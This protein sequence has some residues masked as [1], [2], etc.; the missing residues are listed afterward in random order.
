MALRLVRELTSLQLRDN[1]GDESTSLVRAIFA[2]SFVTL[3]FRHLCI[4]LYT[5]LTCA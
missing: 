3:Y 1:Q 5:L 2:S 4:L